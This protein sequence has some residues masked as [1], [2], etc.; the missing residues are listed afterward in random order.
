MQ[1][2]FAIRSSD[3]SCLRGPAFF[4]PRTR[5]NFQKKLFL[6]CAKFDESGNAGS[7]TLRVAPAILLDA[8]KEAK[9]VL[10]LFLKKQGLSKAVAS[11]TINKAALFVDHLVSRLHSVHKTRYL[12]DFGPWAFKLDHLERAFTTLD[13]RDALNQYLETLFEEFGD[14]LVDLV[15]NF[16]NSPIEER[17]TG[18]SVPPVEEGQVVP[19]SAPI[20]PLN[21]KKLR[22][23]ARLTDDGPTGKLPPEIIYL[24]EL[25]IE[26]EVIKEVTRKYT[27]FARYCLD[28][29]VKPVVEFL[30]DLGVPKSNIPA[31]FRKCPRLGGVS[32]SDHLIPTVTFLENLGVDKKQW[33]KVI[34][35]F[36]A[37][38]VYSRQKLKSN[39]DC[40]YEL[41]LS[42]EK[43]GKVLTRFP[44]ILS[45]GVERLR[46][47]AQY[48]HSI[49]VDVGTLLH[50]CPQIFGLS[51]EANLKHVTEFFLERGF[52]IEEVAFMVSSYG[53]IYTLSLSKNIMPKWDFFL[54]TGYPKAGLVKSPQYFGF[55][56]EGRIKPRYAMMRESGVT[57]T[58][59]RLLYLSDGDSMIQLQVC[60]S[61]WPKSPMGRA[62]PDYGV[63]HIQNVFFHTPSIFARFLI[64]L[65]S[66]QTSLATHFSKYDTFSSTCFAAASRFSQHLFLHHIRT[67]ITFPKKLFF[68]RAKFGE[69]FL[70]SSSSPCYIWW[71][72]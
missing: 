11:R 61:L 52:S 65:S 39:L 53:N 15:E 1:A 49:G 8:E 32:V 46:V 50:K 10:T 30:L 27:A 19:V 67:Q 14:T 9:A 17:S 37:L 56:L 21:S 3:L 26:L 38:P 35:R 24:T 13:I 71:T 63:D 44:N 60:Y 6:C 57:L 47:T 25:G 51:I 12:V 45:Y 70:F 64:N 59:K 23:L 62:V 34:Y 28:G 66:S 54:T 33:A 72:T 40:L 58:M 5:L 29:K 4:I 18:P 22:A 55:S 48:F 69:Q 42:T 31:I 20:T 16:P 43:Q 2:S 68:C 41:G 7:S 36:P